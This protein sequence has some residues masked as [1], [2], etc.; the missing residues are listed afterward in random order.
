MW[1]TVLLLCNHA[2]QQQYPG[3]QTYQ[4]LIP[5][6]HEIGKV[7]SIDDG[8]TNAEL[9]HVRH[10]GKSPQ[11]WH[12]NA[13]STLCGAPAWWPPSG[14]QPCTK[15]VLAAV[16]YGVW[17]GA[18]LVGGQYVPAAIS[19]LAWSPICCICNN[20]APTYSLGTC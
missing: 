4:V 14:M 15:P 19:L 18:N 5:I 13:S 1:G 6:T 10:I 7:L 17:H 9:I 2:A 20:Y 8:E 16:L 3:L 12:S 11:E